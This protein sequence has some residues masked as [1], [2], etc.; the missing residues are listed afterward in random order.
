MILS[1]GAFQCL[2]LSAKPAKVVDVEN[3]LEISQVDELAAGTVLQELHVPDLRG[4]KSSVDVVD[5]RFVLVPVVPVIPELRGTERVHTEHDSQD[6]TFLDEALFGEAGRKGVLP[7][8]DPHIVIVCV[9]PVFIQQLHFVRVE[10]LFQRCVARLI[11]YSTM[12]N[13]LCR[14]IKNSFSSTD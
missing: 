4:N 9:Q 10:A 3:S 14:F 5:V 13:M 6:V 2:Q 8:E 11:V 7:V 1:F 12:H